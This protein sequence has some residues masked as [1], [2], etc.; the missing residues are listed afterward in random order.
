MSI[1]GKTKP[2]LLVLVKNPTN[3]RRHAVINVPNE[4]FVPSAKLLYKKKHSEDYIDAIYLLL[5]Q[6]L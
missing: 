6:V 3:F 5:R 1:E 4:C 2:S